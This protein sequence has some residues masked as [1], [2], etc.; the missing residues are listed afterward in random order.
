MNSAYDWVNDLFN[1]DKPKKGKSAKEQLFYNHPGSRLR[2]RRIL[3]KNE[4]TKYSIR[5]MKTDTIH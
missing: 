2:E 1:P 4:L 3:R 5:S